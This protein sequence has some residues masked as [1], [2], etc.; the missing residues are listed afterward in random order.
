MG[1]KHRIPAYSQKD[2]GASMLGRIAWLYYDQG[3]R[4]Q[5]IADF[6]G[7]SRL[8]VNRSLK[9][10]RKNGV[11]EFRIHE[12][13]IRCFEI[14]E[15]L[16]QA[17]RLTSVTVIPSAPDVIAN[18][19]SGAVAR[20]TEALTKCKTIALGGGRTIRTMIKRL[21]RIR[22]FSV[23]QMVS[24]GEFVDEDAVYDPETVAHMITTKL[25][26][27][28]HRFEPPTL[29]TPSEAVEAIK[30]S[31]PMARA[32]QLVRE[33]DVAFISACDVSTSDF[34]FY[35]PVSKTLRRELLDMGVVGEIEGTLYT[36]DGTPHET[37]F[38]R[39][40]CV[41]LPMNCPVVLVSGGANKIKAM[42]GAIR[43]GLVNELVTDGR[44]AEGMLEYF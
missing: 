37:V 18:V 8:T 5:E 12:K 9:E 29:D 2:S 41:S 35:S 38:S 40:E 43:G 25:N 44:T 16:R 36:L 34:V 33:A 28:C 27:K 4:Q 39:R 42:V 15:T 3:M 31:R 32:M 13:H 19:A 24:M 10:A 6:I 1:T 30:G 14:E 17:T 20:F 11:V 26:V 7:V 22:R 21:P 23:E